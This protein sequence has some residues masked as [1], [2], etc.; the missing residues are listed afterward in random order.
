MLRRYIYDIPFFRYIIKVYITWIKGKT[1]KPIIKKLNLPNLPLRKVLVYPSDMRTRTPMWYICYMLNMKITTNIDDQYDMVIHWYDSTFKQPNAKLVEFAKNHQTINLFS[2]DISKKRL[3]ILF[4]EVFGYNTEIDPL[5]YQG[6]VLEKGN[7]NA[8]KSAKI[9]Q[10][11]IQQKKEDYVYQIV[12]DNQYDDNYVIDYRV[13]IFKDSIPFVYKKFIPLKA[14]FSSMPDKVFIKETEEIFN[15]EEVDN[16]IKLCQA[17]NVE[18]GELDVLRNKTDNKI[19]VVDV[20]DTPGAL[21][22]YRKL[23]ETGIESFEDGKR[24]EALFRLTKTFYEK[25]LANK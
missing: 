2:T 14:R 18:Y 1:L 25:F 4:K 12:I 10:C 7:I 6:Q 24:E 15:K 20:N 21:P 11:P 8:K 22:G 17:M 9:I 13:P 5:L 16:I 3:D 23:Y 19:Y